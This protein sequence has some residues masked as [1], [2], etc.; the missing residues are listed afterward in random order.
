MKKFKLIFVIISIL[1]AAIIFFTII[2]SKECKKKEIFNIVESLGMGFLTECFNEKE[3]KNNIKRLIQGNKFIYDLVANIKVK[4]VPNFGKSRDIYQNLDFDNI[5]E[6]KNFNEV[7]DLKGI[8]SDDNILQKYEIK[9][10]NNDINFKEWNRSHGNNWNTKFYD[11]QD[12]NKNNIEKLEL[13]WKYDPIEISN[14]KKIWKSRIGINPIYYDGI[15]YFVSANNE[16]NAVSADLGKLIWSKE[17]QKPMGQRGILYHKSFIFINSGK[18]LFKFDAKTGKLDSKF[19]I[20]GSVDIGRSL[21]APV[22]YNNLIILPNMKNEI[23]SID[24]Q[25]GKI[26]HKTQMHKTYNFKLYAIAWG[27]AALDEKNGIYYLVT[28]N[29][30]PYHVGI[31]RP[32]ENSNANSIIAFDINKRKIIWTFQ[33]VRH[34]LWNLDVSA[35]P[36][37]ADLNLKGK[38]IETV[39]VTTKTG[40]TLLFERK[41]G[42]PIYDINYKDVPKSNVPNEYVAK[43]QIFIETP[44]RFS[45]IEFEIEDLRTDLLDNKEYVNNL[46]KNSTYGYFQPPT[47]GKDTIMYGLIGG[48]NWYGAAFNPINKRLFVPATHVPFL[49]KVFPIAKNSNLNKISQHKN[50]KI[51]KNKCASCH[52]EN[53]NGV[54]KIDTYEKGIKYIPSLVGFNIFDPIKDKMKNLSELKKKHNNYFDITNEEFNKLNELFFEWDNQLKNENNI[55]FDAYY[56]LLTTKDGRPVSKPPWGTITS[57]NL[58]NGTIDWKIPFGYD[59][60]KNVGVANVGGLSI[61]SS[62][63]IFANGTSDN[64]AFVIDGDTGKE[65]WKYKMKAAG[66]TPPLI[67]EYK[68]KQYISFLSTGGITETSSRSSSL[69]TFSLK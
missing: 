60:N 40:N 5:Y 62:N 13:K 36:I 52:G 17:F 8:I 35:P 33:D 1:A 10:K 15:V 47:L 65:L 9:I 53:R 68:N 51:Y 25:S 66:T 56:T 37:L 45:K 6:R 38:I 30:K 55:G 48:N 2:I 67:Y 49:I 28:G 34:D 12:I 32:G 57:I 7:I 29:P 63:L 3:I 61:S 21:I 19:G 20:S 14:S 24:L 43:K 31:F 4:L 41:T 58:S 23:V 42:L 22:I 69:Y 44:E 59:E 16:L 39:I 64:F 46:K 50:Y 11:S 27:G 18:K 54:N 26:L